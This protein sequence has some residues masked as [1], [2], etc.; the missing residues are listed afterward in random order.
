[1][2]LYERRQQVNAVQVLSG[3]HAAQLLGRGVPSQTGLDWTVR[4]DPYEWAG[5]VGDYFLVETGEIARKLPFELE[6]EE[7]PA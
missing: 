4:D 5:R 6:W 2:P 1:M 7:A 3:E